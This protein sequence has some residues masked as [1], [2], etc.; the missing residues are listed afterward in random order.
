MSKPDFQRLTTMQEKNNINTVLWKTAR[1]NATEKTKKERKCE[2]LT[3]ELKQILENLR[4][5]Y[6]RK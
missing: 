5:K 6:F 1:K 2:I 3:G 4:S